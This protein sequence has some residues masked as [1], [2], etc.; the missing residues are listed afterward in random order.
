M[1]TVGFGHKQTPSQTA[2]GFSSIATTCRYSTAMPSMRP[3]TF[4][5]RDTAIEVSEDALR[6]RRQHMK[7][8]QVH[9]VLQVY[10]NMLTRAE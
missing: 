3:R 4:S 9:P 7:V 8:A 10:I 6:F 1:A 5:A 2:I